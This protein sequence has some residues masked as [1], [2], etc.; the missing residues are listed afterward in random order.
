MADAT[1]DRIRQRGLGGRSVD[2]REGTKLLDG[3]C[4]RRRDSPAQTAAMEVPAQAPEGQASELR[5]EVV[6]QEPLGLPAGPGPQ[7]LQQPHALFDAPVRPEI[8]ARKVGG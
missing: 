3:G 8:R 6:G 7:A 5:V 1:D 2:S 4:E